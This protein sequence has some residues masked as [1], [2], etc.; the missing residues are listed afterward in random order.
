MVFLPLLPMLVVPAKD[1]ILLALKLAPDDFEPRGF[2]ELLEQAHAQA[3]QQAGCRD[4]HGPWDDAVICLAKN[5][6]GDIEDIVEREAA[7]EPAYQAA[8]HAEEHALFLGLEQAGREP[9][10][11]ASDRPANAPDEGH[12]KLVFRVA[13][14]RAVQP[15]AI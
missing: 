4:A 8:Q 2:G 9:D 7:D 12:G 1:E 11:Q 15:L 5:K 13:H 3:H 6:P 10:A 14:K